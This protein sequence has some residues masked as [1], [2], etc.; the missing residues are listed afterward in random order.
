MSVNRLIPALLL[1]LLLL[2]GCERD[3]NQPTARLNINNMTDLRLLPERPMSIWAIYISATNS[4][5]PALDRS[6]DLLASSALK[7]GVSQTFAIDTCGQPLNIQVIFSD[8]S[9][10]LF[11]TAA[12]V[13]CDTDYTQDV[14]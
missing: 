2:Q 8:G 3:L 1:L 6:V 14:L 11:S 12:A 13:D 9:E 4:L 10:Q 5:T 7:P